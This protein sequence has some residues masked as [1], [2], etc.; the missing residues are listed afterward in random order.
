MPIE[1]LTTA[2]RLICA[3][4]YAVKVYRRFTFFLFIWFCA[5]CAL[6]P[7]SLA[8]ETVF[9]LRLVYMSE[10]IVRILWIIWVSESWKKRRMCR[11]DWRVN[12][13]DFNWFDANNKLPIVSVAF[14]CLNNLEI[15]SWIQHYL[16]GILT[17]FRFC[18]IVTRCD[19]M[20]WMGEWI[21]VYVNCGINALY[22]TLVLR[23]CV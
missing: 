9:H 12:W 21:Y 7:V 14:V 5:F 4:T 23:I 19:T 2:Q 18:S 16:V 13:Y 6:Q 17:H 20:K 10:N 15:N 22:F 3:H 1:L 11:R 8:T